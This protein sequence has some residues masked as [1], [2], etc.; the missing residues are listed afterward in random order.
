MPVRSLSSSVLRWPDR[1]TVDRAVR[2]W[3]LR[4]AQE[5]PDLVAVGYLGSYA[6]G[7]WSVGSDIDLIVV[8]ASSALPFERRGAELDATLLPVPADLLVYTRDEWQR[9][10]Q[11]PSGRRLDQ[12]LVWVHGPGLP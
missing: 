10:A 11:Q 3:A 1:Q 12:E 4:L 5:R 7:D 2:E 8:L 6:R 9:V